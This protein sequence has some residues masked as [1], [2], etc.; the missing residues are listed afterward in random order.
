MICGRREHFLQRSSS[1]LSKETQ[2]VCKYKVC[3]VRE[4]QSCIDAVEYT[5]REF[6]RIDILVNGAAGN[7]LAEAK[8]LTPKGFATVIGIDALGTFNMCSAVYP[9]MEKQQ[10]DDSIIINISATLQCPAT[11]WQAHASAAKGKYLVLFFRC[12]AE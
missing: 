12:N 1:I 6:G 5:L 4:P 3:D 9:H 2:R 10:Q 11:H 8:N 7:F